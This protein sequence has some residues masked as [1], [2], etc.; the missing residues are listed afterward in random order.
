MPVYSSFYITQWLITLCGASGIVRQPEVRLR[1]G[2]CS[3]D[4]WED[5]INCPNCPV[6][7]TYIPVYTTKPRPAKKTISDGQ[8]TQRN[9]HSVNIQ[10]S[11]TETP[12]E[13]RG[14]VEMHTWVSLV[15]WIQTAFWSIDPEWSA[16]QQRSHCLAREQGPSPPPLICRRGMFTRWVLPG[17]VY[18]RLY[19][20]T[21]EGLLETA[22]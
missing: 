7:V 16:F 3:L 1:R 19:K 20:A 21:G 5:G 14:K 9:S 2:C 12:L 6:C 8:T 13:E 22:S 4:G 18:I 10:H 11:P 15:L 17:A